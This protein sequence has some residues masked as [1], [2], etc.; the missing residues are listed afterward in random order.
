MTEQEFDTISK[1][2]SEQFSKL[3]KDIQ[4]AFNAAKRFADRQ[5]IHLDGIVVGGKTVDEILDGEQG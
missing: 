2:T 1:M 5:R 4:D 3:S